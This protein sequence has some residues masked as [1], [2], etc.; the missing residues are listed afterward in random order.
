M[1]TFCWLVAVVL[2]VTADSKGPG[3][4]TRITDKALNYGSLPFFHSLIQCLSHFQSLSLKF[5]IVLRTTSIPY[6]TEDNKYPHRLADID[7]S[8]WYR[9]WCGKGYTCKFK[10]HV[11][12]KSLYIYY[13]CRRRFGYSFQTNHR[14]CDSRPA[15]KFRGCFVRPHRVRYISFFCLSNHM[16]SH[17]WIFNFFLFTV[18]HV[19]LGNK[20]YFLY[21]LENYLQCFFFQKYN[22]CNEILHV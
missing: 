9:M 6:G 13:S 20:S 12:N 16:F 10:Y 2:V 4:K 15:R 3:L 18:W 7:V 14:T 21:I 17:V 22:F 11:C 5:R 8:G 1:R 19:K